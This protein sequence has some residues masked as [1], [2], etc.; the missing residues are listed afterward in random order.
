MSGYLILKSIHMI[1]AYLAIGL[2]LV[3][4][5]LD[6][7]GKP[8]WR[9]TVFRL[10]PHVIYTL[11]I[12]TAV[13]LL[14]VSPWMVFVHGWVTAKLF[15]LFGYVAAATVALKDTRRTPIRAIAAVLALVQWVGIFYLATAKPF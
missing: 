4:L 10:V 7:F 15:L 9:S 6:M 1:S 3:F 2:L 5:V 12:V 14:F 13:G 8:N 11:L